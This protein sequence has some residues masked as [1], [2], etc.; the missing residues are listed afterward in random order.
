MD[1]ISSNGGAMG[2]IEAE[3]ARARQ[4]FE[5]GLREATR[6][7][8]RAARRVVTPALI[9]VGLAGGALLLLAA[10]RLARRP[11]SDGAF[12]RIVVE[13][14][15]SS[16]R[17]LPLIGTTLARWLL[18]RQLR[19]DGPIA[20]LLAAA[21]DP[22]GTPHSTPHGGSSAARPYGAAGARDVGRY[23]RAL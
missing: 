11:S 16:R 19:G 18:E 15:R 4:S 8:S 10:I 22:H 5:Q 23:G 7:G 3:V 20:A 21:R 6:V 14:P 17:L 12:I 9:G 13:P 1:R 2:D